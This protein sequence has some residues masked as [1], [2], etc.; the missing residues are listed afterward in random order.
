[1]TA[2]FAQGCHAEGLIL[3]FLQFFEH[4]DLLDVLVVDIKNLSR[5][6][7]THDLFFS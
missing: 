3:T 1:M 7:L 4:L 5:V 2:K 6:E